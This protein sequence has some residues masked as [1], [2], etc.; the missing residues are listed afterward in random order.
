MSRH[1]GL[2]SLPPE[3]IHWLRAVPGQ[4]AADGLRSAG[5]AGGATL[6]R[7]FLASG[8]EGSTPADMAIAD[9]NAKVAAYLGDAGWGHVEITQSGSL[10]EVSILGCWE[11]TADRTSDGCHLTTGLLH[12]F[13]LELA[14]YDIA[15]MEVECG[16]HAGG[17]CRF[18]LGT[19]EMMHVLYEKLRAGDS[20]NDIK[21]REET[22]PAPG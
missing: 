9:F 12:G 3:V 19:P 21:S 20:Y 14:G 11:A 15:A 7:G 13:F 8:A 10:I 18:A 6:F 17:A 22:V 2:I 4:P 5:D 16:S 1:T